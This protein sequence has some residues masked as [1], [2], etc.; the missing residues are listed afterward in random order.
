MTYSTTGSPTERTHGIYKSLHWTGA[1]NFVITANPKA[2]DIL[3]V[4]GGGGGGG[5]YY[6]FGGGGGGG[7][8]GMK[9]FTSQTVSVATHAITIGQGGAGGANAGGGTDGGDSSFAISGGSTLSPTGGGAGVLGTGR[10]GGSGAPPGSTQYVALSFG[11]FEQH[12][13]GSGVVVLERVGEFFEFRPQSVKFDPDGGGVVPE[14]RD[15]QAR[16]SGGDPGGVAEPT[17]GELRIGG[18]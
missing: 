6:S 18:L 10:D 14:D 11:L 1:G 4:S 13:Q 2:L 7:A 12:L 8:G 16:I 9:L 3:I 15:P 17:G 5:G